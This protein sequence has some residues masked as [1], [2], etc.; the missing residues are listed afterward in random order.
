VYGYCGEKMFIA[1]RNILCGVS[2]WFMRASKNF[3]EASDRQILL[4]DDNPQGLEALFEYA[5][6]HTYTSAKDD[7]QPKI[8]VQ[9][10][11]HLHVFATADIYQAEGLGELVF[12]RLED[13]VKVPTEIKKDIDPLHSKTIVGLFRWMVEQVYAHQEKYFPAL[14]DPEGSQEVDDG[15]AEGAT[16][17]TY[18]AASTLFDPPSPS[19]TPTSPQDGPASPQDGPTS[20]LYQP[21]LSQH[22]LTNPRYNPPSPQHYPTNPGPEEP[23][24][25]PIDRVQQLLVDGA[26]KVWKNEN[27]QVHFTREHLMPITQEFPDFGTDLA[28]AALKTPQLHL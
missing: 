2:E 19:F 27:K 26:M 16:S 15:E 17:P 23:S 6:N 24:M 22:D 25:H 20:P 5:Y 8:I 14:E 28:G 9:F 12:H 21:I 1:H 3:K 4:K 11:Q 10:K 13:L 7:N 18:S